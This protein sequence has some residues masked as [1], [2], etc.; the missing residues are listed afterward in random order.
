VAYL[1]KLVLYRKNLA[2]DV[3]THSTK[4]PLS[5]LEN[6]IKSR[7]TL[8]YL[9]EDSS[10]SSKVTQAKE[11]IRKI[12]LK[13]RHRRDQ[14]IFKELDRIIAIMDYEFIYQRSAEHLAK[15]AYSIFFIRNKISQEMA[16]W[17]M[18]DHHDVHLFPFSLH[19]TFGSKPVLGILAHVCLKGKYESFDEETVLLAIRKSISE[20]ELVNGSVYTFQ[21]PKNFIKTLYF[22]INKKSGLPFHS[23]EIKRLKSLLKQEIKFCVER[24]VPRIFMTRNEEEILR[25]VLTLSREIQQPADLPQ[26]MIIFDQQ[27]AQEAIF[28]LI[29]VRTGKSALPRLSELFSSAQ[30]GFTYIPERCQIVRYLEQIHPVEANI[31]RIYLKKDASFLRADLSLNFYLARQKISQILLN[32]I[33]EFR[34]YNGGIILKQ[35]E[36]LMSFREAFP[37]IAL[38]TPDLL[39]NFYYSLSPVEVQAILSLESLK[40]LFMLFLEGLQVSLVTAS[41]FCLK[42]SQDGE[43]LFVVVRIPDASFEKVMDNLI[44]AHPGVQSIVSSVLYVQSTYLLSYLFES[45]D[46]QIL[47]EVLQALR[48]WKKCLEERQV[49]KIVLEPPVFS[50]DPRIGGDQISSLVMKMLFEGLM[51]MDQHGKLEYGLAQTVDVSLD[52]KTYLFKLKPTLW[53][54][55]SLVSAFDFEY[56]WKK[57]LSPTFKTPFAYLFYPIKNAKQA[58]SGA[59]HSDAIGVRALD[60]TKLQVELEYPAPY[61]LELTAHTLY[62]PVNRLIDQLHP[63]WPFEESEGYVCNG[64]FQ[65]KKNKPDEGY[66]LIR[67]PLYWDTQHIKLEQ[68]VVLRA[69][70][71][72]AYEMFQSNLNHWIGAPLGTWDPKFTLREADDS[73]AFFDNIVYWYV[74]NNQK[75]PF[76]HKKVRRAFAL[77]INREEIAALFNSPPAISPLPPLHCQIDKTH[78]PQWSV[79]E[80]K[81]LFQEALAEMNMTLQDFPVISMIH[82]AGVVRNK[83]AE[84]IKSQWEAVFGVRCTIESMAWNTL[85]KK[86]TEGNFQ[87][88]GMAWE[89]W[90]ND[91]IY[92]LNSFRDAKDLINFSKWENGSYQQ[93]LSYADKEIDPAKRK[94]YYT[95]AEEILLEEMPATAL[96]S[97]TSQA[98]KKKNLH[99]HFSSSLINFKWAYFS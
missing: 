64:A 14:A 55:G 86:M 29:V 65:L 99:V 63:N 46:H 69:N 44:S 97:L 6:S 20:A 73:M 34:D 70:R 88:G 32:A 2:V 38:K 94:S 71:Y 23:D 53:S 77:A 48:N 12:H 43:K 4:K 9:T 26:V 37:E 90:I 45:Q 67:N 47:Q 27:T 74:F 13:L 22:E 7:I 60:D 92:T 25:N 40:T 54:N 31:F 16:L 80:A 62:S 50:L 52:Q 76:N 98:F 95:Q 39:E 19:Y 81:A 18:K 68:A 41:D 89:A 78:L 33:G 91:P 51:R 3:M 5:S 72:Q 1:I 79:E 24:L 21:A 87:V 10:Y 42:F 61:F 83:A 57:I 82:L 66:E 56:A 93:I 75:F 11:L 49:L 28:T 59:L 84:L 8:T 85:F 36:V 35:R 96:C 17:P 58:K 30:V 15:I